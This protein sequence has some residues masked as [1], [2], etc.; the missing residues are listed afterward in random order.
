[1]ISKLFR[2]GLAA[3]AV[4]LVYTA[5]AVLGVAVPLVT[6]AVLRERAAPVL[7]GIRGWLE[8]N[9]AVLMA[10]LLLV[11]GAILLGQGVS[12]LA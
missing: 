12:G 8:R 9:N 10:I 7:A 3:L 6:V 2:R 1:M 11:F 5:I 4:G